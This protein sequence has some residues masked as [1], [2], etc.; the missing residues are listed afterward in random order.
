MLIYIKLIDKSKHQFDVD[1]NS[2]VL[3][4]KIKIEEEL[5]IEV[6][7]QRLIYIGIPMMDEDCLWRYNL[8]EN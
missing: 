8:R 3:L 2:S 7:K 4:L 1:I 6:C 5:K